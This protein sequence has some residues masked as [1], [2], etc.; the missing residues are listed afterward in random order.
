MPIDSLQTLV[1]NTINTVMAPLGLQVLRRRDANTF[2]RDPQYQEVIVEMEG[3]LRHFAFPDLENR[4]QRARLM[5]QLIGT[6]PSEALYLVA[7]LNEAMG[8]DGDIC[9]FGVAQG[10][11]SALMANEIR[12]TSK[13]LWLFDSFQGLP[14]PTAKDKLIHDI[15]NLG[16]MEAYEG[17]MSV[18]QTAVLQRLDII[19]FPRDR[20]M[21]V[22]GFI[23]E[24]SKREPLPKKVCFAYVDFDFYEPIQIALDFLHPRMPVGGI[25]VVDDYGFFSSGAQSAAD[26]FVAKM[27]GEY[28]MTLPPK[29]AGHFCIIRK[30]AA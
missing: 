17:K 10:A 2:A 28:I 22:P 20:T 8:Q 26:E 27:G 18:P 30:T 3:A 6:T 11:T 1:K 13:R 25:V 7:A 29:F 24:T 21:V 12:N 15:F 16:S 5:S 23:E 14:K 4:H 9:E 19:D